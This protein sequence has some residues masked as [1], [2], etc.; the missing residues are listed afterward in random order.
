M[1]R[2]RCAETW[3]LSDDYRGG[4]PPLYF[5]LC[6]ASEYIEFR[7][8]DVRFLVGSFELQKLYDLL[9][10]G[11]DSIR[12]EIIAQDVQSALGAPAGHKRAPLS[13]RANLT[14]DEIHLQRES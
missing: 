7:Q 2:P 5:G 3:S 8:V 6:P 10:K 13:A 12:R 14:R 9:E 1:A 11:V 4:P